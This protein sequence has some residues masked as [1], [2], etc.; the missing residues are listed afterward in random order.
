MIV[1]TGAFGFIGSNMVEYLW[2]MGREDLVLIDLPHAPPRPPVPPRAR[3]HP[4]SWEEETVLPNGEIEGVIHLGAISDTMERDEQRIGEF[5]VRYTAVIA[6]ECRRRGIPMS[7][8]SS[9]A[10]YGNGNGPLNPYAESKLRSEGEI[11]DHAACFRIF[12]VYGGHEFH[13]GRMASVILRWWRE[14]GKDGRIRLFDGSE[15]YRRDFVHVSDVCRIMLRGLDIAAGTYDL[16]T[17]TNHDFD[18][19][20]DMVILHHGSGEKVSVPMPEDLRRQYQTHTKASVSPWMGEFLAL[21]EGV[22]SYCEYLRRT[23]T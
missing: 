5:N 4:L 12:N 1:V 19:L 23:V 8:A 17:G 20:A 16:G 6:A 10:V 7:F 11:A 2:S 21:C 13:K 3:T 14:L 9:A 22:R 15:G 18:S